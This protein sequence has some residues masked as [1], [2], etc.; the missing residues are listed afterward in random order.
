LFDVAGAGI[1]KREFRHQ[2]AGPI[3][4]DL[5]ACHERLKQF[6]QAEV[7]RRKWLA[8]VKERAGA[9][10]VPYARELAALGM[11]L[12]QQKKW[13]DAEAALRESLA[14][15]AKKEPD[16]WTTFNTH[17]LLGDALWGQQRYSEAESLL[18]AGYEGL[19]Q[20]AGTIPPQAKD[21]RLQEAVER[22]VRLYEAWGKS[23]QAAN[24]KKVLEEHKAAQEKAA[25]PTK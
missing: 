22:L 8:V 17:S 9:D 1:E 12:L 4:N 5:I 16:V 20:R 2:Y 6:D 21:L 3:V 11:N 13:P 23:D 15:R 10:S 25:P 7:W 24:W 19:K 14:V 18:L